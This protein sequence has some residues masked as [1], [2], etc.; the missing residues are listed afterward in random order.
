M[1]FT[2][3][4]SF[5]TPTRLVKGRNRSAGSTNEMSV[6][7]PHLNAICWVFE[8]FNEQSR[9]VYLKD[10][11]K[12]VYERNTADTL[13]GLWI[14]VSYMCEWLCRFTPDWV[15]NVWVEASLLK[16]SGLQNSWS[17]HIKNTIISC[18]HSYRPTQ[19]PFQSKI[20]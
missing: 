1:L 5:K 2:N 3:I 20:G 10:S 11:F 7:K 19:K 4:I 14:N 18:S 13:N 16:G 8:G 15:Y 6:H 12:N 17:G 9:F